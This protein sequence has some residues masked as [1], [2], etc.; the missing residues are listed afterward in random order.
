MKLLVLYETSGVVA[1]A[2]ER[3]G[4]EATTADILPSEAHHRHIQ[5][6]F[7]K[8]GFPEGQWDLVIAHP[9]CT[10]L[11]VSGMHWTRRGLRDPKLTE[12]A[13]DDVRN[14]FLWAHTHTKS[15]AVENPVGIL[16]S[17]IRKP[18]QCIQPYQFGE[19]ASKKTCLW[20]QNLP[21]LVPT[22][23]FPPRVVVW[24]GKMVERWAN[25]TDSGQNRLPPSE[26]RWRQRSRT[27]PGIAAAMAQQWTHHLST[28]P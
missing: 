14:L 24:N 6:D 9:P 23:Q 28:H 25:Q 2:F 26:N 1:T 4:W 21:K 15:M 3:L 5:Q 19:D 17:K 12:D 13:L 7:R 27:Y 20:L 18:D 8:D 11:C 22:S 10:Y 16:S